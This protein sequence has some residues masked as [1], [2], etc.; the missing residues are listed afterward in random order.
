MRISIV[1]DL[2]DFIVNRK[3]YWMIP[4]I[5]VLVLFALLFALAEGTAMAPFIYTIF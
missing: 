2:I 5:I 3:K 4:I 1:K